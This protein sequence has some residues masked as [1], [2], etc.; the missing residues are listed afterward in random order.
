VSAL[1]E[2]GVGVAGEV[3]DSEGLG[4]DVG[5]AG[6]GEELALAAHPSGRG[7]GVAEVLA[8]DEDAR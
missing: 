6:F 1:D 2:D 4:A 5:E 3:G 8:G 7:D